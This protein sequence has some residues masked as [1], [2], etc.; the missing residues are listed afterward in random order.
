MPR[1][2]TW[3]RAL[4]LAGLTL[5]A[6]GALA[7]N[8]TT[9][10]QWGTCSDGSWIITQDVWGAATNWQQCLYS[11]SHSHWQVVANLKGQTWVGSYPHA[12]YPVDQALNNVLDSPAP[13]LAAWNA[14]Y[15]TNNKFDFA[16]DLWLSGTTYEVMIWLNWN[17]TAPIGGNPF[18]N[19]TIGGIT[20][21]VYEGAGGSGPY[22]ISFLPQTGTMDTATNFNL[23]GILNWISNLKWSGGPG[24]CFWQNPNFE[25]VQLGWEICDTYGSSITY[26]MNSFDVYYG[27][28]NA[29][30]PPPTVEK[31]IWQANFNSTFPNGGDY[32]FSYRDGSPGASG[33][34]STNLTGG[35][36]D[37]ASLEY[38]VDLSAWSSSP[39]TSYSGFGVGANESPLPYTLTSASQA[40][41]RIYLSAKVGG[42]SAGVTNVPGAVDLTFFV[43]AG[44]LTPSNAASA[45]VFDLNSSLVLSTNWQACEFD[46]TAM[47][48][49]SYISGAQAL[50]NQ[51]VSQVNQME[52]QVTVEGS[53]DVG[54]V[55]GYDKNNTVNIENL[56]VVELVPGLAPLTVIQTSGQTSLVWAD[57]TNG[58]TAQLQ[59]ATKVAGP[60]LDVPGGSSAAA[61]PYAV[62][63]GGQQQFFRTVWVP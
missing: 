30:P 6:P 5:F 55:F 52:L 41:Y 36:G 11:D 47:Q 57:P 26:T 43:P 44:T 7:W 39:P 13:L 17:K 22:C 12:S 19:A 14:S 42:T 27:N 34:L 4:I 56:K 58:G 16:Y 15:P 35:I 20:Y 40:S 63:L 53:P 29:T 9:C 2:P 33:S 31:P 49:A 37:S 46:G 50:F 61:S 8:C 38:T 48:I 21:N 62:P 24:G 10:D 54:A 51:Y 28:T 60:Y 1:R 25:S 23:C 59:S 18:T 45:A 3:I 32:G